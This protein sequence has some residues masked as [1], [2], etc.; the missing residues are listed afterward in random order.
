MIEKAGSPIYW[1][2]FVAGLLS[3]P[4]PGVLAKWLPP[5]LAEG[6]SFFVLFAAASTI[7]AG[8]SQPR[9]TRFGRNLAAS[10]GGAVLLAVLTYLFP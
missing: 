3:V 6:V 9:N 4:V 7:V 10:A 2:W 1:P 5:Y 8:R